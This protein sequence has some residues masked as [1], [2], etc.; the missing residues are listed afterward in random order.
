MTNLS[1]NILIVAHDAGAANIV[2]SYISVIEDKSCLTL[3]ADGP[4]VKI[5]SE[6]HP[7][8][9]NSRLES[10]PVNTN[11]LLSGTSGTSFLEHEARK[12]AKNKGIFSIG[13]IDHWVNYRQRFVRG[14]ELILPDLLWVTDDQAFKIARAEFPGVN[15]EKV[16]NIYLENLV[17]SI[18]K[19]KK[20][21]NVK[22]ILYVLEPI[23][24]VWGDGSTPGEFQAL[25]YFINKIGYL[26]DSSENVEIKLRLH[27]SEKPEKY[28]K[29]IASQKKINIQLDE[30][31]TL[32][33][34]IEWSEIVVGCES[35]AMVVA[36]N[37]GRPTFSTI[38]LG[39][40]RCRLPHTQILH[41]QDLVQSVR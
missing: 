17:A 29:W 12:L 25:D 6:S 14:R 8:L 11:I 36:L 15:V 18:G 38:P 1:G 20:L 9:E 4:A 33:E 37:C 23:V 30:K 16:R 5:F 19:S 24:T 31:S 40:G 13:V 2:S 21:P 7:W 26:V 3:A 22:K 27:P 10:V 39:A 32:R 28:D 35:Y 41:I 34:D